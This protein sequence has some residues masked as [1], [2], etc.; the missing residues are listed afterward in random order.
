VL[1][2]VATSVPTEQREVGM[3]FQD[4]ALFPHLTVADNIAFGLH[5]KSAV[6][7]EQLTAK[8]L[9]LTRLQ[10]SAGA[11][12]HQ[13]SGGQQQRV[14][15]ARALAPQPKL[16]LLDEPFSNL[17]TELRRAL[18]NEVRELLKAQ[19]TTAIL[20]THD[21]GEAFAT[22]DRIGVMAEGHI[23]QWGSARA[24]YEAPNS[25][26]VARFIGQGQLITGRLDG[27]TLH[28]ALGTAVLPATPQNVRSGPVEVLLRPWNLAP[29]HSSAVQAQV[30][31]QSFLGA[32]N[33]TTLQL[34]DGT[35]VQSRHEGFAGL[36]TGAN[37]GLALVPDRLN[38]YPA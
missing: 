27:N 6:E 29:S 37:T 9:Q 17:D 35:R 34:P 31:N 16:L 15:L 32:Y 7:R 3:V 21:Q 19:G 23:L 36:Q 12:P 13:L 4:Y 1:S 8:M 10:D 25:A 5:H 30:I 2:D 33:M 20:V 28:T 11:W 24:L 38:L 22:A 14:A 18:C 26:Q